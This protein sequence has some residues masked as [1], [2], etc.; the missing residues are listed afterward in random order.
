MLRARCKILTDIAENKSPEVSPRDIL[1][2][3]VTESLQY[4]I[5]NLRGG[6]RKRARVVAKYIGYEVGEGQTGSCNKKGHLL[7]YVSHPLSC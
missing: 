5:G 3:H 2:K 4:L 7:I 1:S 6:G